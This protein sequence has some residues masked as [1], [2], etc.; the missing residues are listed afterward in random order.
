MVNFIRL[1]HTRRENSRGKSSKD[2]LSSLNCN[3]T[4][5]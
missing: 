5:P 2:V 3:W 1:H 4:L